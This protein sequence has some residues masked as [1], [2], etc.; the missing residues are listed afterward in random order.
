M[1]RGGGRCIAGRKL[2]TRSIRAYKGDLPYVLVTVDLEE[3]VRMNARIRGI[4]VGA[5]RVGLPVTV[6][7]ERATEALVLPVFEAA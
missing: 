3:G 5:L 2:I 6:G 7:F 1:R 4:G